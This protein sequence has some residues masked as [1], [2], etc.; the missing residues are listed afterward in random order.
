ML[1]PNRKE[2]SNHVCLGK[3]GRLLNEV[4]HILGVNDNMGGQVKGENK[5]RVSGKIA[6][7]NKGGIKTIWRL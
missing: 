4:G 6:D 5:M 1:L 3:M 7:D 2:Q